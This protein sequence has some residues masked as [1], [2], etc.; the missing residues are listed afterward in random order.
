MRYTQNGPRRGASSPGVLCLLALAVIRVK[1]L[2]QEV[3]NY[4]RSDR[5]KKVYEILHAVHLPPAAGIEEGQQCQYNTKFVSTQR[6]K[7]TLPKRRRLFPFR[8]ILSGS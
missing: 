3:S 6:K 4:L 5:D 1:P 7:T 8:V 2:A